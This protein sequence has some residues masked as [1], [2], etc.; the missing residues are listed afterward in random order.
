MSEKI[1]RIRNLLKEKELD[2]VILSKTENKMYSSGFTGTAGDVLISKD[3]AMLYTDFRY[4]EQAE[5]QCKDYEIIEIS[6]QNPIYDKLNQLEISKLGFEDDFITF[7]DYKKYEKKLDNV[8]LVPLNGA[9]T[10]IR[11]IK[12]EDE[13][14]L[15]EKAASI[16][17]DALDYILKFIKPG[18]SEMSIAIELE[19]YM[20][21]QG[22]QKNSFD[23]IVASGK[24]SALPHGRATEKIIEEGDMFTL[25]F[26]CVYKGYCS[27]MTRSF[28]I[29]KAT[30]KQKEIYN[31]VLEAQVKALNSVKPGITGIELDK[32][33]RDLITKK[34]YGK[35][36]GHGLG[37]GLGLEVHELPHINVLGDVKMQPGM[38]ITIEPGV[39]IS[40][41]GGVRIEDLVLVTETGFRVLSK[42]SKE[43]LELNV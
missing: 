38:I 17:D 7:S 39:Y 28:V 11:S 15:I 14:A 32:I 18:V 35:N 4:I 34:G 19:H 21:I 30:D 13:I 9:L 29:G 36:F 2:A 25:D 37:H 31:V 5:N 26:G 22:A 41:Y 23:F 40:G 8:E 43:L 24:R 27:D 42:S 12:F 33:A 1:D 10:K 16:T 20:K 3:K 6:K